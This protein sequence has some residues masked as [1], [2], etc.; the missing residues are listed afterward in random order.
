MEKKYVLYN[1]H[2]SNGRGEEQARALTDRLDGETVFMDITTIDTYA[3]FFAGMTENDEVI[4]CGGDGTLNRFVND[5]KDLDIRNSI[6]YYP[7]GSGNDFAH[8]LDIKAE[9]APVCIDEYI[10]DLPTVTVNGKESYFVNGVGYGVDG[11]CC[12]EGDRLRATTD[13][14][15]DYTGIAIKGVLFHYKPTNA[16]VIVDGVTHEFKKVWIAPTMN[17]RFYGGGMIP[18]PQQDRRNPDGKLSVMIFAGTGRIGTLVIFPSIFK[19]EHVKH[20][21]VVTVLTGK[22]ITVKFDS[23]RALQIDGETV[24]GVTEYRATA[25]KG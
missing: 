23:P 25:N 20:T 12:E 17:G 15:I 14:K 16:T 21:K 9:N 8:D 7:A 1:P 6:Y 19:G 13:K 5:T 18:T 4:L 10:K 11:Y 3:D 24:T 2:A 22:D